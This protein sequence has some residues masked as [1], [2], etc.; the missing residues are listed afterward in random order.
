MSKAFPSKKELATTYKRWARGLTW[1]GSPLWT[2]TYLAG[3]TFL[4]GILCPLLLLGAVQCSYKT[5]RSERSAAGY[6]LLIFSSV[7]FLL[8]L[9]PW[10]FPIATDNG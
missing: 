6:R 8:S 7:F 5:L 9:A 1:V 3:E 10:F 2:V 4:Y